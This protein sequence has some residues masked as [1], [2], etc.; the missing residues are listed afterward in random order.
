[1]SIMPHNMCA[2]CVFVCNSIT[3]DVVYTSWRDVRTFQVLHNQCSA[4]IS[5]KFTVYC[6]REY[7]YKCFADRAFELS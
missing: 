4:Q 5:S 6:K 1:M 3:Y 2:A 7:L